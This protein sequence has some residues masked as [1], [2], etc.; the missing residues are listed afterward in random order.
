[1]VNRQRL[2]HYGGSQGGHLALLSAIYAPN[3]FAFVY[4]ASPLTHL[5]QDMI[6]ESGRSFT[7]AELSARDVYQHA[8]RIQC[9]VFIEHGTAD[10]VVS[11][12]EHTR[13]LEFKLKALG[14]P[15]YAD[16]YEGGGH[17]LE[18]I[19]TR[20]ETYKKV[21]PKPLR[22]LRLSA[23]DDFARGSVIDLPCADRILRIDWSKQLTSFDLITWLK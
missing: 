19:I 22:T 8:E 23:P 4:A 10:D 12:D 17:G 15:V 14:K 1:M 16:Y 21:A 7:A 13:A 18:P 20:L 2:F 3:T 5:V 9:P 6:I 11:C